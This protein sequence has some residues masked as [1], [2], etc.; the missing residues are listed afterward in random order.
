VVALSFLKSLCRVLLLTLV[1][2]AC[3]LFVIGYVMTQPS[4]YSS[5][6][7]AGA[8]LSS[9]TDVDPQ[10]PK[11]LEAHVRKLVLD[12]APRSHSHFVQLNNASAYIHTELSQH[13]PHAVFQGYRANGIGYRNVVARF[14]PDTEEMIVIGAHYDS[15]GELPA[16]DDNASGVA[17]LI[18]LAQMLSKVSLNKRVE[19]VAYT[20]EEPP[21][22]RTEFMGSAIHAKSLKTANKRVSL[23][24][25]LE[26]IGFFSDAENSQDFPVSAMGALYPTTG[27]FIALVGHYREGTLS[28]RVRETM[29]AATTLPVHSI[30]APAFVAGIDFSDHLNYWNEGFVGMMVTD[31]A[32]MRN[33]NYHTAGD[34]PET[35]D[36]RRMADVVRAVAAVVI[37]EAKRK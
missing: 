3:A 24:L 35:L 13:T 21:Y 36:Y 32:F 14:G 20:L 10:L 22:F 2:L 15:Y 8:S 23:M 17:G 27:N 1:V 12:F 7:S 29:R 5:E 34:T 37:S 19:L 4:L 11:R 31:T 30:N 6:R 33:K 16:A 18:E 25:S 28:R 26:C 9:A